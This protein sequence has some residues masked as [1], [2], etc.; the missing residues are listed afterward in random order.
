MGFKEDIANDLKDVFY[1]P[2]SEF[3]ELV[4]FE[5]QQIY[6]IF[7]KLTKDSDFIGDSIENEINI[8]NNTKLLSV[9]ESDMK[10][11]PEEGII[12]KIN[13]EEHKIEKVVR[14]SGKLDMYISKMEE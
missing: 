12:V 11:I 13:N 3:S 2:E 14:E 9:N 4:N 10:I 7:S 6:G 1:N 5:G 8:S